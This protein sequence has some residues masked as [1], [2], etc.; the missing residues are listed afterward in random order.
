MNLIFSDK[1]SK[2]Y[3][4]GSHL[5]GNYHFIIFVQVICLPFYSTLLSFFLYG[6]KTDLI[7]YIQI[8]TVLMFFFFYLNI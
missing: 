7:L 4:D 2:V 1:Y 8:I 5:K 3:R 6:S